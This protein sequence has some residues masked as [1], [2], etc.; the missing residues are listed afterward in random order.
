MSLGD[1]TFR[2]LSPAETTA[3]YDATL[4]A[5]HPDEVLLRRLAELRPAPPVS[6]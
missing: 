1:G 2:H 6:P 3:L 5:M 4:L